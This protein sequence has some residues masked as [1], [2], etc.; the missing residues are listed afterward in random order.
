MARG[1]FVDIPKP[2]LV[3]VV[4]HGV[5]V[6]AEQAPEACPGCGAA[7]GPD[8]FQVGWTFCGC[9][10]GKTMAPCGHRTYLCGTCKAET[11]V[12]HAATPDAG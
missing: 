3:P 6:W 7:W 11:R 10:P 1:E 9:Y 2:P 12:G 4:Q 8:R 5:T